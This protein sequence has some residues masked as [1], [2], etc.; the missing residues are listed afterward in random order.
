MHDDG[1]AQAE[2]Q[3]IHTGHW[4]L[5]RQPAPDRTAFAE[6]LHGPSHAVDGQLH[7]PGLLLEQGREAGHR[8]SPG[9]PPPIEIAGAYPRRKQP[10]GP[11]RRLPRQGAVRRQ[12]QAGARG[13]LQ[14]LLP[15]L[16]LG[17]E[18]AAPV[19]EQCWDDVHRQVHRHGPGICLASELDQVGEP[20]VVLED[21]AERRADAPQVLR[22]APGEL[23]PPQG[24]EVALRCGGPRGVVVAVEHHPHGGHHPRL[25]PAVEVQEGEVGLRQRVRHHDPAVQD[26]AARQAHQHGVSVLPTGRG[27][28]RPQ[29]RPLGLVAHA[30]QQD[31]GPQE[32]VHGQARVLLLLPQDQHGRPHRQAG[33]S[34]SPVP[35][36]ILP[37][38]EADE[39]I[40]DHIAPC[41]GPE[42]GPPAQ[43]LVGLAG[44]RSRPAA[45]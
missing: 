43:D 25:L 21:D 9:D 44:Q 30:H 11:R 13:P 36:A 5:A 42:E 37:H 22:A 33:Q 23:L 1:R 34:P 17:V 6:G 28:Q 27:E 40:D 20:A 41:V 15:Q 45:A 10:D 19:D 7:A 31:H 39:L 32:E 14:H 38:V 8:H 24:Q 35:A 12:E 16:L 26:L 4:A 29:P 3:H 2:Q 18:Q